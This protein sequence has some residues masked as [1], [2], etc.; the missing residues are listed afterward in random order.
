MKKTFKSLLLSLAAMLFFVP[1][2]AQVT[3]SALGGRATD[4]AGEPVPG[5]AVIAVHVPT[6]TQYYAVANEDG[7]YSIQ[8][9]RAGGPYR[10]EVSCLGYQSVSVTDFFLALAETSSLDFIL[11]DDVTVLEQALVI[12][13]AKSKFSSVVKT[14]ASTNISNDEILSMPTVS[15]SITD[16]IRLSPYGGDGMNFSGSSGRSANFTVDGANFNNNFGLSTSLPGGGSPISLDAIEEMQVVVSPFDVRQSNF[17]GGGINAVTKSG[18]NT[19]RGSAYVYHQNENMH[20]NRIADTELGERSLDRKTT[21]G[22][23]FGGP[24]I[25]DKLFFFG[26]FEFS[27]IPT[28]VNRWRT[29]ADGVANKDQY[30]TRVKTSDA[31]ALTDFLKKNYNYDPGSFSDYPANEDN[32]KI[33]ARLDW[34]INRD[35]HLALRYNYTVNTYWNLPSNSRDLTAFAESAASQ[36]GLYFAGSMY[37]MNNKI[38][39]FSADLNSRLSDILSN[40]LLVTY[41]RINDVRGS[42]SAQFPF[43]EIAAGDLGEPT[44]PYMTFGYELFTLGNN[45]GNNVLTAKDDLTWFLGNHKVMAGVGFEYQKALNIYMRNGTGMFRFDSLSEF[46]DG[47]SPVGMAFDWGYN[48][49]ETPAAAVRFYQANLYGQDEWAVTKNFKLNYGVRFDTIIFNSN[50]VVTNNAVLDLNYGGRSIDTGKW[51][52]TNVQISPRVGFVWDVF[53]NKVLNVRGGTGLFAG[54]LPLVFFTNMPTNSGQVKGRLT[55][56]TDPAVLSQFVQ[57]GKL[58]TDKAQI[59][60]ILNGIDPTKYPTVYDETTGSVPS[61]IAGVDPNFKMPQVWKSSLAL[62]LNIP[63]SFPFSLTGEFIYNKAINREM[64]TNYNIKDNS[65]WS[66]FNGAD[67]RHIYPSDYK[68]VK[69]DAYVLTNTNQGYGWIASAQLRMQPVKNLNI[70]ASYTHTVSKEVTG[71]PGS[72][73]SAAWQY[74]PSVDGPNFNTLHNSSYNSMPDRVMASIS[75]KDAG[76]NTFGLIYEGCRYS[77]NSYMYSNDMNG[78]GVI[79]DLMYI[80]RDDSEICFATEDDRAR[81]WAYANQ[82]SYLSSHK[83]E[84][85]EAYGV[86]TPFRHTFDFHYSH[87]FKFNVGKSVNSLQLNFDIMNVA[88]LFNS[89]WGVAKT[90]SEGALSGRILKYEGINNEGKP[91]FSTRVPAGTQT[92]D[93]AHSYGN[94]W[95]MQ[96]GIRY[97]FN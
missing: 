45:V 25:K 70:N 84:Y 42:N 94:C 72:N 21:Y 91:F 76:N 57:G 89:S 41:S 86:L 3:T 58:V 96:V 39:T 22:A 43:V 55:K 88:N 7:K 37:S 11:D 47:A 83:G 92:W 97:M 33:L 16:V 8:G 67:K 49:E 40:Q 6:G 14:G 17:V 79:Y 61:E 62:D 4:K 51:P 36:Y 35:N 46:Y 18:T 15:R 29:S 13:A 87:D 60:K 71:M 10:V 50:D 27:Q 31:Q 1:A 73:A 20:G 69:T 80:P 54:R 64:L 44:M 75:Y 34:N 93:Y 24:I 63:V 26:N 28:V 95:Y 12:S 32:M 65:G 68:Y 23:T 9:M 53:G 38:M 30:I 2:F 90:F 59:L 48:G 5:A 85:A 77:G 74:I 19:F 82:D 78:D 81:Y 66:T 56:M 52:T